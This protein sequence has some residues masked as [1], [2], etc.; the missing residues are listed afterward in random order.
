MVDAEQI[1]CNV[2]LRRGLSK[3]RGRTIFLAEGLKFEVTSLSCI[4]CNCCMK[5]D[6]EALSYL[7]NFLRACMERFWPNRG[8]RGNDGK[9]M[10]WIRQRKGKG[11][12]ETVYDP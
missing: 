3:K 9:Q 2:L 1:V 8:K 7:E 6:V 4:C 10:R 11:R 5:E 12:N